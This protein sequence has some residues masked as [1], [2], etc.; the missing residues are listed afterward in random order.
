MT[1]YHSEQLDQIRDLLVDPTDTQVT[2]DMKV[3]YLNQGMRA[4]WPRVYQVVTDGTTQFVDD[5][6]EYTVPAA[7]RSGHYVQL[8]K[9]KADDDDYFYKM[10]YEDYRILPKAGGADT[11]ILGFDPGSVWED[12]YVR[13]TAAVPLTAYT[14]ANYTA[15]Q[16]EAYTG[17]DYTAEAPVLYAMSRIMAI[18]LDKRMGYEQYSLQ[19][20]NGAASPQEI[21][22]ASAYWLDEFERRLDEWKM[23]LPVGRY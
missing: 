17:P 9:S 22:A 11:L 18:P 7:V 1:V 14:A 20:G 5:T 21:L 15:A 19:R 12:G 3:H 8:E 16:S 4:M 6:Y 23:P 10:D 13:I 2:F